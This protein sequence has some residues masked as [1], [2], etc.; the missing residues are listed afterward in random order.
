[1]SS[2]MRRVAGVLRVVVVAQVGLLAGCH[3]YD[4]GDLIPGDGGSSSGGSGSGGSSG[5]V[6]CELDG[7]E[8]Q[9][10]DSFPSSD[11]CNTCFCDDSGQ[12]ACTERDCLD[13]CG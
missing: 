10:G 11:G 7:V 8:H 4:W 13:V 1:K 3:L 9:P 12:V 2:A 5:G 6:A